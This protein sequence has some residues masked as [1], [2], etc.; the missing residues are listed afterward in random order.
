[1]LSFVVSAH[2]ESLFAVCTHTYMHSNKQHV[3]LL[4]SS[5]ICTLADD[6]TRNYC[7]AD[8]VREKLLSESD[9]YRAAFEKE[10]VRAAKYAKKMEQSGDHTYQKYGEN[11]RRRLVD[12]S[13]PVV[14]VPIVFHV[15]Y[16]TEEENLS[17]AQLDSALRGLL[18]KFFC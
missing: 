5:I 14:R 7:N 4:I 1:M 18:R 11:G 10:Q 12:I 3:A 13:I 2:I 6:D 17:D 16:D 9:E 15:L 8:E